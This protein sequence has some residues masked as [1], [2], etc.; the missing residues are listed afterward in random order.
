MTGPVTVRA[1]AKINLR[2]RVLAREESGFHGIETLFLR[3]SL[4]DRLVLEPGPPGIS[5]SV[6]GDDRVPGGPANLCWRAATSF[7]DAMGLEPAVSI[8]LEKSVPVEAGLGGGSADAAAVLAGL[9]RLH[10]EPASLP[11]IV[12]LAAR[13]GSDVPF[14]LAPTALGLAW[15]RGRRL[16]P[17]VPPPSRPVVLALPPFGVPTPEAYRWLDEDR[18]RGSGSGSAGG[19]GALLPPPA[20]LADWTVL[21]QVAGNDLE[22]PVFRRHPELARLRDALRAM[23]AEVAILCGSGS[24]VAG[25]FASDEVRE[26]AAGRLESEAGVRVL[27]TRTEGPVSG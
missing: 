2:L 16:L 8:R 18:A 9:N 21:R 10:G 20:A 15:E 13:I 23:G 27:R 1:G 4:A 17:L 14:G 11:E 26:A 12:D 24:A 6:V 25:V 19:E 7:F 22:G 3:L 5:L